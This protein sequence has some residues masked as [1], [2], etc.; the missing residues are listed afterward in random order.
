[1][2]LTKHEDVAL[3]F[4]LNAIGIVRPQNENLEW[5]RSYMFSLDTGF[6]GR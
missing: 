1:M 3:S 2:L 6:K 4:Y 5:S